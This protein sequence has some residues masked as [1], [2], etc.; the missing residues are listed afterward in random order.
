M[1]RYPAI[2]VACLFLLPLTAVA[3]S[4]VKIDLGQFNR[5]QLEAIIASDK[6]PTNTKRTAEFS[7]ALLD[8]PYSNSTLV[9]SATHKEQLILRLDAVDCFTFIDYVEAMRRAASF[10]DFLK[11][12][13]SV[14]YKGNRVS[15]LN[16]RHFFSD[17]T[18]DES[19][20]LADVTAEI[21]GPELRCTEKILNRK[22]NGEPLLKGLPTVDRR[23]CYLP[24]ADVDQRRLQQLQTGDYIGFYSSR[25]G[26]DVSHTGLVVRKS[27]KLYLRH[28]SSRPEIAKVVD[29]EFVPYLKKTEG[30]LIIRPT[31]GTS[32]L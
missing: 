14:R 13:V 24:S 9:G 26:L 2:L 4:P 29:V 11:Q 6:D 17:W 21:A 30:I 28:A 20:F 19:N 5:Y 18:R 1:T 22:E 15:Y 8:T 12:L 23:I 10:D 27:N 16:R 32:E 3:D 25:P 31:I 7:K